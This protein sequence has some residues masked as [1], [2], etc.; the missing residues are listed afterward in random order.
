MSKKSGSAKTKPETK[1]LQQLQLAVKALNATQ[2]NPVNWAAIVKFV[3]PLI[4]RLAA[5]VTARYVASKLGKR[6]KSNIPQ[7]A[8]DHAADT[9]SRYVSRYLKNL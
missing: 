5:R 4:V 6:M 7:E 3:A 8:A 2:H 9:V 1:E